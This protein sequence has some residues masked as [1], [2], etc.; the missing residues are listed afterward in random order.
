MKQIL[1]ID[2]QPGIRLLLEEIFRQ[3]GLG[4]T[5]ASNGKEAL[6]KLEYLQPDCIL[7]D[8]KM[9]GMNGVEVLREI[10]KRTPNALVMMMTAYSEIE[11]TEEAGRL[12]ID[13]HFTKPFDIFEVR[14]TVLKRLQ[15]QDA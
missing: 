8:M 14:D 7:L 13:N 11:L 9:P 10:R 4:T 12:G 6:D 1:I 3:A 15:T 5:L 2:D